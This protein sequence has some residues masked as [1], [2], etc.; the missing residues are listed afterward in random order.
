MQNDQFLIISETTPEPNTPTVA[1]V[2]IKTSQ[3]TS[4]LRLTLLVPLNTSTVFYGGLRFDGTIYEFPVVLQSNTKHQSFNSSFNDIQ[5][6]ASA[7]ETD[8]GQFNLR[9][10]DSIWSDKPLDFLTTLVPVTDFL[11]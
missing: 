6:K 4:I 7:Y 5:K 10:I 2:L 9:V 8:P 3:W 1:Y 11:I